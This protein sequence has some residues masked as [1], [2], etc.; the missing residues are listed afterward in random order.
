MY[1]IKAR[2]EERNPVLNLKKKYNLA[3]TRYPYLR[4]YHCMRLIHL[5]KDLARDALIGDENSGRYA[6]VTLMFHKDEADFLGGESSNGVQLLG[7]VVIL[8]NH[9]DGL[10]TGE[11]HHG[12]RI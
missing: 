1:T 8:I 6:E 9:G 5:N 11:V 12:V 4:V 3:V 7:D 10:V 2:H